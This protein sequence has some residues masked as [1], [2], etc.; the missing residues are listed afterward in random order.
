M[1]RAI[2]E[3]FN[4]D[5]HRLIFRIR[6]EE[7]ARNTGTTETPEQ[8]DKLPPSLDRLLEILFRQG[9]QAET[10]DDKRS[11]HE[12]LDYV[13]SRPDITR[14]LVQAGALSSPHITYV[15]ARTVEAYATAFKTTAQVP[16]QPEEEE[17]LAEEVRL[18]NKHS[19]TLAVLHEQAEMEDVAKLVSKNLKVLILAAF[20]SLSQKYAAKGD[21]TPF[22]LDAIPLIAYLQDD[23]VALGTQFPELL[24]QHRIKEPSRELLRELA[25]G[26][27]IKNIA[28]FPIALPFLVRILEENDLETLA[29]VVQRDRRLLLLLPPAVLFGDLSVI[30]EKEFLPTAVPLF[31]LPDSGQLTLE[32]Q[33]KLVRLKLPGYHATLAG[34]SF[35]AAEFAQHELDLLTYPNQVLTMLLGKFPSLANNLLT[36][37][38]LPLMCDIEKP[39]VS[40]ALARLNIENLGLL[41][42][43]VYESNKLN[44]EFRHLVPIVLE[45]LTD[46]ALCEKFVKANS[47]GAFVAILQAVPWT[48]EPGA[49][50]LMEHLLRTY[51]SKIR[52]FPTHILKNFFII[53]AFAQRMSDF[54]I[55]SLSLHNEDTAYL[56][57]ARRKTLNKATAVSD[58]AKLGM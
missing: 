49:M 6:P 34:N 11:L 48:E 31:Q 21:L 47:F 25:T 2:S 8:G 54:D 58:L 42:K 37:N 28:L 18:L 27:L 32:Q 15:K 39:Y 33:A 43:L 4:P 44:T 12:K 30:N 56:E 19:K 14:L 7:E 46:D 16:E 3:S 57:N 45:K 52:S 55:T 1:T 40:Q 23:L 26:Q 41:T 22:N 5:T 13:V 17:T 29:T 38:F 24:E 53:P 35:S 9:T 20:E 36:Q 10:L 50:N 51:P